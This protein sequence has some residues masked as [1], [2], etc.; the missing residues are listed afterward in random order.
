MAPEN[1]EKLDTQTLDRLITISNIP[2]EE[3][4]S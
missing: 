2:K 4:Q 3:S 1:Y